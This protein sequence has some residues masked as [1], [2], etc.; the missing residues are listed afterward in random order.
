MF[1]SLIIDHP[2]THHSMKTIL[3]TIATICASCMVAACGNLQVVKPAQFPAQLSGSTVELSSE[4]PAKSAVAPRSYEVPGHSIFFQ[5][6]SGGSVGVG[7]LLGPLGVIANRINIDRLTDLMGKSGVQSSL[8]AID[9]LT[10]AQAVWQTASP[11]SADGPATTG[12]L[13]VQPYITLSNLDE[14]SGIFVVVS[15]RV[16]SNQLVADGSTKAWVGLYN[17]VVDGT[18]PV[19][20]LQA[21][22]SPEDMEKYRTSISAGYAEIRSEIESDLKGGKLPKRQIAWVN[23]PVLGVGLPDD[24]ERSQSGRLSLRIDVK[25]MGLIGDPLFSYNVYVFPLALALSAT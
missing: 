2:Q 24:V 14:K 15:A 12:T 21:S 4:R 9:A 6:F 19:T 23:S 13:T 10:E 7:L 17:Y 1:G 8:Y 16:E 5:Q 11:M 3:K 22:M 25:N 20:A 18:L